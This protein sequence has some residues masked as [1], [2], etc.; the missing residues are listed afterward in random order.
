MNPDTLIDRLLRSGRFGAQEVRRDVWWLLGLGLLLMGT[1]LGLR[2]PWPADEPRFALIVRDMVRSG[3]WLIPMVGGDVYA[4]K[5]PLY[6]WIMAAVLKLTGH[7]RVAFLFPSLCAALGTLLLIYDLGRRCWNREVGLAAAL[8]LLGTLQFVWQGRQAQI[9]ASLCF[10]TTLGLYGLLR[11]LLLGPAWGW[12]A[13]G[14]AAAGFG[15]ISKGVGFLPLLVLLP[16]ALLRN[17]WS[18]RPMFHAGWRWALGPLAFVAATAVWLA[19]MLWASLHDPAIAAYR[20]EIL[21]HQTV[22]RY[23]KSWH[24]V[25]PFWYFLVNVIPPLWLPLSALLPWLWPYWRDAWRRRDLRIALPLCWIVLVLL[26]FSSSA[27]KRGVYVLPA[28]PALA[29]V[30]APYIKTLLAR[31][32]PR[33]VF[34]FLACAVTTMCLLAAAY[35]LFNPSRRAELL[36]EYRIDVLWPLLAIGCSTLLMCCLFK[37]RRA[38]AAYGGVLAAA[39]AIMG[40]WVSPGIDGARSGAFFARH[41]EAATRRIP[42]L[43]MVAYKE[44]Y[45]LQLQRPTVNFGH[46][47]WR[48]ADAEADD[49]A[50]WLMA[51]SERGLLINEHVRRRCFTAAEYVPVGRANGDRW[52]IVTGNADPGC[53]QRGRAEAAKFYSPAG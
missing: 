52:F 30:C 10:W 50:A 41:V 15:V 22:N 43:G 33:R 32:G 20:D 1:G 48:E 34:W 11:H 28:V 29:L 9:D 2:D 3:Q 16:Y 19:P 49:A 44:Q 24:H 53:V 17:E 51:G 35:L 7:L 37:A 25:E 40:L 21:F 23:A 8:L 13:I 42:N 6:F 27:G 45:L 36:G 46:A 5:P 31:N 38:A 47:R 14:W 4:D 39:L 26:F 12:Y 18:P